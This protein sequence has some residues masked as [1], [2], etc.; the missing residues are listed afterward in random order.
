MAQEL[1]ASAT[2]RELDVRVVW[3]ADALPASERAREFAISI[4]FPIS[5]SE[6]IAL[7]I[8]ELAANVVRH[9][10]GGNITLREIHTG[11]RTGEGAGIEVE[12]VEC[13]EFGSGTLNRFMEELEICS[14]AG[15][16]ARIVCRRWLPGDSSRLTRGAVAFGAATR[17]YRDLPENGDAFLFKQWDT[18]ALIGVIDGL[19]H[20]PCAQTAS[21]SARHYVERHF[22]EP[23]EVLFKGADLACRPTRG[24]V[25]ALA[26]ID[27][28]LAQLTVATVGNI[29]VRLIGNMQRFNIA[30]RR[31]IVGLN[32]P[33]AVSTRHPWTSASTLIIHSDGLRTDWDAKDLITVLHKAPGVIA[34]YLLADRGR[35]DDDAAVIVAK[36]VA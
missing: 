25:M 9:M 4:G 30:V 8:A 10:G 35:V 33:Q 17:S 26:R 23:L 18:F 3:P 22:S 15:G 16:K 20:G 36:G 11:E 24:V 7:A 12:A 19:G 31:G 34:Q 29:E 21:Q 27:L 2:V 28:K 1:T 14:D 13:A 5:H 32:A 6:Q